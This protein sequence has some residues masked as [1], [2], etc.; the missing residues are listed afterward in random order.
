MIIVEVVVAGE[1]KTCEIPPDI[2]PKDFF[3]AMIN[4]CASWKI[5][6]S[7]MTMEEEALWGPHDIG[8]RLYRCIAI[9]HRPVRY[10]GRDYWD[11]DELTHVLP[12]HMLVKQAREDETGMVITLTLPV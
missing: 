8:A 11:L 10:N 6:Y 5:D 12:E 4:Q 9:L 1:S 7:Q 3:C 2:S